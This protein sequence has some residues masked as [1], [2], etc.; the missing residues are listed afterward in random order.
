MNL[1]DF[2]LMVIAASM[3]K[4]TPEQIF[5]AYEAQLSKKEKVS[6][7][8]TLDDIDEIYNAYPTRDERNNGRSTGKSLAN[9]KR[10]KS[11]L[12]TYTKGEILAAIDAEL[13]ENRVNGKWLKNFST[14]LNNLPDVREEEPAP[15]SIYQ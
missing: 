8:Y 15:K 12:N 1:T 5:S 7:R 14:F 11:L 4:K 6:T 9:K 13:H 10:I 2:L 3:T